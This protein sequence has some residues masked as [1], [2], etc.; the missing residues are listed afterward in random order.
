MGFKRNVL[1]TW[2]ADMLVDLQDVCGEGNSFVSPSW[3]PCESGFL[4]F[5][6]FN[7]K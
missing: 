7:I 4:F 6:F 3:F 1:M 2:T 5:P